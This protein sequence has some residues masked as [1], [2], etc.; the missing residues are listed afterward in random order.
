M[1][2]LAPT[3]ACRREPRRL[4]FRLFATAGRI[5]R[6]GRRL[7]LRLTE[8]SPRAG[9]ITAGLTRLADLAPS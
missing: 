1:L 6:G 2:A 8:R 3:A 5:V 7:T 9:L 4:R